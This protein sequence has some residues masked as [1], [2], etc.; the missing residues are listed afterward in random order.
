MKFIAN[1]KMMKGCKGKDSVE[2]SV[3]E[4]KVPAMA[5][6]FAIERDL[7]EIF[8]PGRMGQGIR[9]KVG[10]HYDA[11][12]MT[13]LE[14]GAGPPVTRTQLQHALPAAQVQDWFQRAERFQKARFVEEILPD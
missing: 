12:G 3:R 11:I 14:N 5:R 10:N 7:E 9:E 2:L 1:S 8:P 13:L 6:P 4:G